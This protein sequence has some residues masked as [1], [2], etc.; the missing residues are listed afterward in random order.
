MKVVGEDNIVPDENFVFERHAFANKGMTRDFTTVP[1]FCAL[2]DLDKCADL[3][4]VSN[5]TTIQVDKPVEA[6]VL[7]QSDIRSNPLQRL[8]R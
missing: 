2:L 6:Y 8:L 5:F 1:D 7:T 4:V 3:Y